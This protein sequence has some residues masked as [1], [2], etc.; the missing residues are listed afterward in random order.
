MLPGGT[1]LTPLRNHSLGHI[2]ALTSHPS[3]TLAGRKRSRT[4]SVGLD[5]DEECE[6]YPVHSIR[7]LAH[8]PASAYRSE[9]ATANGAA[10]TAVMEE[11]TAG[12]M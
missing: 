1:G 12:F 3:P 11:A 6:G 2:P 10:P 7:K 5:D 4:E 9:S 8:H